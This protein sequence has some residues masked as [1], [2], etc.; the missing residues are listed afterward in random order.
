M[1]DNHI[2]D[3][4][5]QF[6]MLLVGW[7]RYLEQEALNAIRSPRWSAFTK[8]SSPTD[9]KAEEPATRE[10]AQPGIGEAPRGDAENL[11]VWH[12]M[13]RL[14]QKQFDEIYAPARREVRRRLGESF[15]NPWLK[16]WWTNLRQRHRA[17]KRGRAVRFLRRT[18]PQ[19]LERTAW[20][21]PRSCKS[22]GGF[23]YT[24][25]DLATLAY[26][27]ETWQPDEIIYVTDGRQQLHFQ[28]LFAP[29]AAGIPR[30][31]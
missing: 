25:T 22:D 30:R 7:K 11:D 20:A 16:A 13:I 9:A 19:N 26:R 1:S 21:D 5:T 29:F 15:Y 12:E 6:G 24:T 14:S 3:W 2:G 10:A 8:W 23:N 27:L 4:G 17:R 28:Q 31:G 18:I